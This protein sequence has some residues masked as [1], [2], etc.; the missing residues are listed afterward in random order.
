MQSL[1]GQGTYNL[2]FYVRLEVVKLGICFI[3]LM[4][5]VST[6]V[7]TLVLHSAVQS[8]QI[9]LKDRAKK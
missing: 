5:S 6:P 2:K 9:Q 4:L 3:S 7:E 1:Q 8:A